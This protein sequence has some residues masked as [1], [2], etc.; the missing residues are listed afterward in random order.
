VI[1]VNAF[2]RAAASLINFASGVICAMFKHIW[3]L[4][5]IWL[6]DL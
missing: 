1:M 3:F 6:I 2:W 4:F 5:R